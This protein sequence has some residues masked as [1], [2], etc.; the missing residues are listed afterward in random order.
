M[1]GGE[2][3]LVDLFGGPAADVSSAVQEDSEEADD[4]RVLDPDPGI[5]NRANG[6]R[7]GDALQQRKV[8]VDVEPLRLEG[9]EAAG[10]LLEPLAHAWR[11]SSPFLRWKSARLLETI[12]LRRKVANFSYCLRK[13]FLKYARKAW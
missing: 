11:W 6:Y 2:D 7:Q 1:E 10:D 8:D 3:G 5:A 12:S 13:A 9:G 4:A